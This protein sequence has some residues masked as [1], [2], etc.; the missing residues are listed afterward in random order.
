M[1][2][3]EKGIRQGK[4]VACIRAAYILDGWKLDHRKA[5]REA[6]LA[7]EWVRV[8][9]LCLVE[10]GTNPN[11]ERAVLNHLMDATDPDLRLM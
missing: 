9:Q 1:N 4:S 6:Y 10:L 5:F 11:T 8:Y 7:G 3:A 2:D